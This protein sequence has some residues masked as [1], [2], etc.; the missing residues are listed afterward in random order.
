MF[1]FWFAVCE[2]DLSPSSR[3]Q[4]IPLP[5]HKYH[6]VESIRCEAE[7]NPSP[8]TLLIRNLGTTVAQEVIFLRLNE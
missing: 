6:G 2:G 8:L 4:T 5:R 1:P 3:R 7:R